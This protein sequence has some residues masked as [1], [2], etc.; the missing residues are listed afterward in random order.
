MRSWFCTLA[1]F[2]GATFGVPASIA[3]A[4]QGTDAQNLARSFVGNCVQNE[5][6]TDKITSAAKTF[7][8]RELSGDMKAMLGPQDPSVEYSG[9]F[10]TE[11]ETPPYLLG[12]SKGELNGA[13]YETCSLASPNMNMDSVLLEVEK[14]LSLGKLIDDSESGGQ[15]YRVW[16]TDSIADKSFMSVTSA[17]KMGIAGGTISLSALSEQ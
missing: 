10:V 12:I 17:P 7:G 15:R 5:G 11:S 13:I 3:Q 9:W 4:D 1:I 14:L 16:S 2:S 6:R 8:W